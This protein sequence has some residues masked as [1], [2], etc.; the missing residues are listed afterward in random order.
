MYLNYFK[1]N[2]STSKAMCCGEVENVFLL[3]G[4]KKNIFFVCWFFFVVFVVVSA[5]VYFYR[6]ST[7]NVQ[8]CTIYISYLSAD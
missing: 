7:L 5:L 3:L 8:R 1:L 2:K 4:K 6:F